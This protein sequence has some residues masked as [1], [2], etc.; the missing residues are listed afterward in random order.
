MSLP[1]GLLPLAHQLHAS[2]LREIGHEIQ[3]ERLVS[4]GRY[5]RDVLLVCDACPGTDLVGLAA[6]CR[7][8]LQPPSRPAAPASPAGNGQAVVADTGQ[9]DWPVDRPQAHPAAADSASDADDFSPQ[10]DEVDSGQPP[11][12]RRRASLLQRWLAGWRRR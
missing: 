10:D 12:P 5:A 6:Q 4:D 7:A 1:P 9:D 11:A 8:L 2:L 3:I